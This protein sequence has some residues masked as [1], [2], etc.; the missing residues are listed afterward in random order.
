MRGPLCECHLAAGFLVLD[1]AWSTF[2]GDALF[3]LGGVC[4]I[5]SCLCEFQ[6]LLHVKSKLWDPCHHA[7]CCAVVP[8]ERYRSLKA[9]ELAKDIGLP[10]G[11]HGRLRPPC[12][13][14]TPDLRRQSLE[15][16]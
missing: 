16:A 12:P 4:E 3:R 14:S 6:S 9:F 5:Q 10:M 11:H 13:G 8:W 15:K 1:S 7:C 2:L